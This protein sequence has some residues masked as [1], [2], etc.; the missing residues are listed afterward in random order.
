VDM[1]MKEDRARYM[2]TPNERL[3]TARMLKRWSIA[4]ASEKV[5]VSVNTFNRW[6]R[7]LQ[8]PQLST[9]DMV[10]NAF[11]MSPEELGFGHAIKAKRRTKQQHDDTEVVPASTPTYS[12]APFVPTTA[13]LHNIMTGVCTSLYG[14]SNSHIAKGSQLTG[15]VANAVVGS[16]E[17]M[18]DKELS[19]RQVITTLIGTPITI[20]GLAQSGHTKLLHPEEI[21]SLCGASIPL[22]WRL[23]FEGGLEGVN[24]TLPGYL[25][26]LTQLVKEPSAYQ[27]KAAGLAS[28]CYQL[29][30]LLATQY[31]NFGTALA[32]ATQALAFADQVGD[33]HL[34]AAA[35]IR[36]ALV[37]FYLKR[38]R[39]RLRA[40]ERALHYSQNASSLLQGRAH[41]GLSE[42]YSY[43]GQER[44]ASHHLALA[45]RTFPQHSEDDIAFSY[46]HFNMSSLL[47]NEGNMYLN[48]GQPRRA[49]ENFTQMDR[50]LPNTLVP[51]RLELTVRLAMTSYKLGDRD[52]CCNYLSLAVHSAL[53]TGNQLRFDET[54]DVYEQ[55]LH[56]W[57]NEKRVKELAS[58]FS[59]T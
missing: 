21:L 50:E 11:N 30:S 38:P 15:L 14:L 46:T 4:V 2:A 51:N 1:V 9:L 5:G 55:L 18:V 47:C 8:V 31:Q 25:T 56:Q 6:E 12:A 59:P 35:L 23:Y 37:Y 44:D 16:E 43:L 48:L 32:Y 22:A 17:D 36:Q 40:Y 39:Q 27:K 45:H 58:L 7:G 13:G 3:E 20:L 57:S 34:Q 42:T 49:W 54:Y 26:H 19:R 33:P 28:Q 24:Q 29:A 41:I 53:A 10:C 52:Q